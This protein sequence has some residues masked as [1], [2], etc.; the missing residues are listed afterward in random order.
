[1]RE[2]TRPL[3]HVC[4]PDEAEVLIPARL[5]DQSFELRSLRALVESVPD[6]LGHTRQGE[7]LSFQPADFPDV[8]WY[9]AVGE[10][11]RAHF[12]AQLRTI[13]PQGA[14]RLGIIYRTPEEIAREHSGPAIEIRDL[15]TGELLENLADGAHSHRV[16]DAVEAT[17]IYEQLTRQSAAPYLIGGPGG[18]TV[19]WHVPDYNDTPLCGAQLEVIRRLPLPYPYFDD[20]CDIIC[21]D[22]QQ[23]SQAQ[24]RT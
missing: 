10:L 12:A 6:S 4:R 11:V 24:E 5:Q 1:M 21:P 15:H 2:N 22:C 13:L 23:I 17:R 19:I 9:N 3:L 20:R 14:W 18:G 16:I 7:A 8:P